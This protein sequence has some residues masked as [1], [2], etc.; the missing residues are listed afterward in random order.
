MI[1]HDLQ[2]ITKQAPAGTLSVH[3]PYDLSKIGEVATAGEQH[4]EDALST[5]H[6]L[7]LD[8]NGWFSV[9][10]RV[11]ILE[12]VAMLMSQRVE[13]L[14]KLAASEGGKPYNDSKVEVNRA[15]DGC[16]LA[17]E[18]IRNDAGKVIPMGGDIYSQN[19]AAFT[20][21]QP[22]GL[23]VAVSAFNHPLNLIVHQVA[24]AIAAGCPVIVKPASDTPLSCVA[25]RQLLI[26]AGLPENWCQVF[27]S[28]KSATATKLVTDP[29]VDFFS[30]I[31]S[32]KIGW[33]LNSKLSAGTRSALEHGG[34]APALIYP[35]ADIQNAA[36][37]LAKGG[38]Y[39]AGQVC[40]SAQRLYI[41]KANSQ[42]FIQAL[43]PLAETLVVGDPLSVKT[44]VG[45][46]IRTSECD[47][48][49][50]WVKQAVEQG[51]S[52]ICGGHKISETC[53]QPT[54]LL[55]PPQEAKVSQLEVFG[56]VVCIYEVDDMQQAMELAN[57]LE[58]SFQAAVFTQDID[59]AFY[60]RKHLNASAIMLNDHSAFRIDGMPFAGLKE[61]G[62]G[63]G[64]IPHTIN[65]MQIEKMLVVKSDSI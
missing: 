25:F 5:A 16:K 33:M 39:H 30:F 8:K 57:S 58:V 17:I 1:K 64:G 6:A 44:Q 28:D 14:T 4:L 2:I 10:Q 37:L 34:V 55:N 20:M 18:T 65:D 12:T 40:V 54:I 56:P 9:Q 61:S 36:N 15:I 48:I 62:L 32:A 45:P 53:Y 59:N 49:D 13:E 46:L 22:I 63:V 24:A 23:V 38:F 52:L 19:R 21:K 29:R 26:E 43:R 41:T 50:D 7:Y 3:N 11:A 47:R 35:D 42:A 27:I 60:T 51:A 31:G